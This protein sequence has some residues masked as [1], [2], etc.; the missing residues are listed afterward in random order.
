[1]A[2]E[3]SPD[4][5]ERLIEA[6]KKFQRDFESWMET[7]NEFTHMDARGL[8]PTVS[9]RE[10]VSQAEVQKRILKVA[11]SAGLMAQAVPITGT[12]I[13]VAGFGNVDPIANWALMDSPKALISPDDIRRSI[14]TIVGRLGSLKMNAEERTVSGVPTFGPFALHPTIWGAAVPF[15]TTGQYRVA[16]REAAEALSHQW[17]STLSRHEVD[18]TVFWQ[19]TLSPGEPKPG[20]PKLAWPGESSSKTNKSMRGGLPSLARALNDLATGLNLTI[21]N[22]TAHDPKELS[23]QEGLERLGA[24]SYFARMLDDCEIREAS[25]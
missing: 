7:Q 4:Y 18:D 6:V 17:K 10:E 9:T 21:R 22:V 25:V 23:E 5:L 3:Y 16:V 24:Y 12:Y 15:W 13:G 11:E 19:Q 8:L 1:M 20:E 2:T 14:S